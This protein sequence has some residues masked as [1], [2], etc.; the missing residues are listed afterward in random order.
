MLLLQQLVNGLTIGSTYALVAIGYTMIFGVLELVNMASGALYVLGGYLTLFFLVK[1]GWSFP[2]SLLSSILLT[3]SVAALMDAV[4]LSPIRKKKASKI[5]ALISTVGISICINNLMLVL[6]GTETKRFPD[7]FA[8]GKFQIGSVIITWQQVIIFTAAITMM[9]LLSILTYHSSIG[10]SMQAIAQNLDAARLM[11][12]HTERVITLTFFVSA[13]CIGIAGTLVAMYYQQVDTK[14]SLTV[15]L[16]SFSA[17]VLG[18]IGVL[19]GAILGG[20]L[21]GLIEAF[22]IHFIGAGSSDAIAFTV[23]IVVLL[24]RPDGLLGKK[25]NTK[26]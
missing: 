8:L 7:V 5:G 12:I 16:K 25:Q 18:G 2:L 10:R 24:V 11:G 1:L 26:V 20:F 17:A 13:V 3:G 22:A 14:M 23:L 9:T 15:G 19:P 21:I 6:F 4:A